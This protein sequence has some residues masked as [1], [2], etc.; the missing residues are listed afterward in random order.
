[1]R[2]VLVSRL[3][4]HGGVAVYNRYLGHALAQQGHHVSLLT[5]RQS[6]DRPPVCSENG[7]TIYNLLTRHWYR[8]YRFPVV[9]YYVRSIQHFLYSLR[10]ARQL[11]QLEKEARP[12]IIEF[13]EVGAEG[14]IYLLQNQRSPVVVRCHTPTF[15]LRRYHLE[16][17]M[18]FD[19]TMISAMEKFCIRHAD[20]LTAPSQDMAQTIAR[21]CDLSAEQ[22]RTVPNALDVGLFSMDRELAGKG[23]QTTAGQQWELHPRARRLSPGLRASNGVVVLHVGRLER[24]KGIEVLVR[25]IPLVLQQVPQVYFV[26]IGPDRSTGEGTSWQRRLETYCEERGVL[27]RVH[28]LGFLRQQA[29]IDWYRWADICVVPTLNYESFS[30]TCAQAMAAGLPVVASRIGGIPETVDDGING[31][32]VEPGNVADL[33]QALVTLARDGDMR[34]QMGEIGQQ[35]ARQRFDAQLVAKRM[36]QIY[37]ATIDSCRTC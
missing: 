33:A 11:Q 22:V 35:K 17:E 13:A 32:L 26:F 9:G 6:S 15:V 28:F 4:G 20:A 8:L 12:D 27:R 24:V 2:I 19:T 7:V 3:S 29:M 1:M 34:S 5:S 25:A 23:G 30:Y 36:I 16:Q 18:P 21:T 14:F 10:V 37:T 31:L